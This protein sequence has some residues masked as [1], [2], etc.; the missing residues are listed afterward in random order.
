MATTITP[1]EDTSARKRKITKFAL[2]GVAVL[3]VGA[4]L[5]SAAW[6]DSVFFATPSSAATFE[7]EGYNPTTGGWEEAD[8]A[9][10]AIVLPADAIDQV[11][12]DISDSYTVT[13]P[14]RRQHPHHARHTDVDRDRSAVRWRPAGR[15]LVRPRTSKRSPTTA[16][17]C[18]ARKPRSTS[19]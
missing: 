19:S 9:G 15:C 12:P 13:C 4:A 10:V 16:S 2:A 14:Q 7:L 8:T 3:G 1:H 6:S 18:P 11:G 5:T 17:S